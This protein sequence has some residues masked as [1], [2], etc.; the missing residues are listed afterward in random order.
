MK[1]C[2]IFG[3]IMLFRNRLVI[4]MIEFLDLNFDQLKV[5]EIDQSIMATKKSIFNQFFATF[6]YRGF[7]SEKTRI[8]SSLADELNQSP[9]GKKKRP[10]CMTRLKYVKPDLRQILDKQ[11]IDTSADQLSI[12]SFQYSPSCLAWIKISPLLNCDYRFSC[13]IDQWKIHNLKNSTGESD[14]TG[15]IGSAIMEMPSFSTAQF[16]VLEL[17]KRKDVAGLTKKKPEMAYVKR[18]M[19][20]MSGAVYSLVEQKR[21]SDCEKKNG[22]GEYL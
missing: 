13:S 2:L 6:S 14:N 20:E 5:L 10:H 1:F 15:G 7:A 22:N 11:Q 17:Q 16:C 21:I 12:I 4:W 18:K 9:P 19:Y 8:I 3:T